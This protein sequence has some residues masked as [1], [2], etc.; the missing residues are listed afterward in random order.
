MEQDADPFDLRRFVDAQAPVIEDALSELRAG[1]KRTHWMWLVFPQIEGLGFSSMAK[2]YAIR[3]PAEA[4]AYLNHPVLGDRLRECIRLVVATSRPIAEVFSH[5][6]DLKFRSCVT[7]FA[8][9]APDE[10]VFSEALRACCDGG[11]DLS[12]LE[13]LALLG[14]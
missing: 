3:S 4:R 8:A 10:A 2:R 1:R 12:T 6:D 14:R 9:V 11:A 7:L 13:K 5:P